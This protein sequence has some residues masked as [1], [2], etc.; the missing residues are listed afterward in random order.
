[1]TKTAHSSLEG[2]YLMTHLLRRAGYRVPPEILL[3]EGFHGDAE[4]QLTED[5]W[6]HSDSGPF[7]GWC[8]PPGMEGTPA[9]K[10][11]Q[12][13][14]ESVVTGLVNAKPNSADDSPEDSASDRTPVVINAEAP[15]R[16][17]DR[18]P[19]PRPQMSASR[20]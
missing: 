1:M 8:D 3:R 5:S 15:R 6:K 13:V 19:E 14:I 7:V 9:A 4:L 18:E 16:V 11:L 17:G 2:A 12:A 10:K 20:G